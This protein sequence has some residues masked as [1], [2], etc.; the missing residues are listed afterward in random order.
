MEDFSLLMILS[1]MVTAFAA[2][3]VDAIA[4]GGGL[5]TV[6][7]LLLAGA[8]PVEALATNK[9]Q[10]L[11]G[12][13][14]AAV[15]YAGKGLVDLRQQ[16]PSALA[17][18]FGAALGAFLTTR[19]PSALLAEALP[20]ILILIAAYFALKPGLDDL[21]RHRLV[22][23]GLFGFGIAPVIGFY[24]GFFGP[25][26]GSFYMLGFVS[27]AGFGV[28]RATAHTKLLNF[29]SNVGGFAVFALSG[30]VLWKL[31]LAMGA[32]QFA[33][34]RLGAHFAMRRGARLVKPVLV[35]VCLG[36]ALRLMLA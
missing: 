35:A 31:G 16:L 18:F 2:G 8:G 20:A 17:C 19:L 12:S 29:A 23:A 24:D 3:F 34:A 36:L 9:L 6:P 15:A 21:D 22:S 1:L 14:S 30:A 4:G 32:A 28:L 7:V 10:G 33:G 25:G 26:A 27:L 5:I 11:F 13:G